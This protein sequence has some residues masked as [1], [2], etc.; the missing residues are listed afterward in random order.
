M[1]AV[2][3]EAAVGDDAEALVAIRIA[4]MRESLERLGRFDPQRARDR[5]LAGFIRRRRAS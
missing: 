5:F 1:A 3:F 4:A 2:A